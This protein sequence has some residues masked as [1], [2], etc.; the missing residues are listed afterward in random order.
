MGVRLLIRHFVF[1]NSVV[2]RYFV[3]EHVVPSSSGVSV[4]LAG[5]LGTVYLYFSRII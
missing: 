3:T 5:R 2:A 4:V 1:N